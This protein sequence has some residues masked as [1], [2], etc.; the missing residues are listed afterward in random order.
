MAR[1]GM[2]ME[3]LRKASMACAT[4]VRIVPRFTARRTVEST[5]EEGRGGKGGEGEIRGIRGKEGRGT[6]GNREKEGE[7]S[8]TPTINH[9]HSHHMR[10]RPVLSTRM[11]RKGDAPAEMR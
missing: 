2:K 7:E 11:P 5:G 10:L 9:T 8:I 6:E 3:W 4:S 1:Y